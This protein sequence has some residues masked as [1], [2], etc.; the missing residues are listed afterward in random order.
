M[1]QFWSKSLIVRLTIHKPHLTSSETIFGY[2]DLRVK[3]YYSAGAL[4]TYLGMSYSEKLS[5][6]LYPKAVPDNVLP[7]V[8]EKLA[9]QVHT[10]LDSFI[11]SL[12]K[13]DNFRPYGE[14]L[15]SF[16]INGR[17]CILQYLQYLFLL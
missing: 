9:P 15:H 1:P 6:E 14:L 5:K 16:S 10:N 8:S 2:K 17:S 11:T 12:Q 7:K 13:D 4:E 3:L